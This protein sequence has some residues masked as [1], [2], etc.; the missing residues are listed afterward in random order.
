[1][2]YLV[3]YGTPFRGSVRSVLQDDG[4]VAYSG[5]MTSGRMT[6]AEYEALYGKMN[7]LTEAQLDDLMTI[8]TESLITEPT[9]ETAE[10]WDYALGVLPPAKWGTVGGVEMFH[11]SER[12][13]GDIVAWHCRA[14]GRFWTFND[15]ASR[16]RDQIAA[17]VLLAASAALAAA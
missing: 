14:G 2:R 10:A 3:P 1:M 12:V 5:G 7:V 8:Y 9:E 17:K 6:L 4:T 11:I 15:I 16:D 13:Y